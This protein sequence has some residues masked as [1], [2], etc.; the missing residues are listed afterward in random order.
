[1][2]KSLGPLQDALLHVKQTLS[3]GGYDAYLDHYLLWAYKLI[4]E[5]TMNAGLKAQFGIRD[6]PG[7]AAMHKHVVEL[8]NTIQSMYKSRH[9]LTMLVK[10]QHVL[11]GGVP[12]E[13]EFEKLLVALQTLLDMV[14]DNRAQRRLRKLPLDD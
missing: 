3:K 10:L 14:R 2:S 9:F 4:D 12:S 8:T 13:V 5:S 6:T 7:F 11:G 1:M